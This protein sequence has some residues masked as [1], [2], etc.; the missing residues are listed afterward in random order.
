MPPAPCEK[1]CRGAARSQAIQG[2]GRSRG[3][4]SSKIILTAADPDTALVVD[5]V[6][7]QTGD[8][9]LLEGMIQR[10]E[11]RLETVDEVV[12]DKG[13]DADTLR[14]DLIERDINPVIP[15]KVNRVNPWPFDADAYRDRN[16]IERLIGKLKQ[17]RRIATRYDKLKS[18]FLGFL[19]LVLGFRLRHAV[20]V[21]TT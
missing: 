21:N 18:S 7:G 11:A 10:T 2:L 16:R 1:K 3:G 19:H 15:N 12:A 9:P 17:F 4:L 6:P 5:V 13:F 20:I 8:A 14:T